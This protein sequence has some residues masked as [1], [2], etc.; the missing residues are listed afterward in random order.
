VRR[1]D[2]RNARLV[3]AF[4]LLNAELDATRA[5]SRRYGWLESSVRSLEELTKGAF[6]GALNATSATPVEDLLRY[7]VV[8]ELHGFGED[9]KRFFCLYFLQAIL[10]LRKNGTT[11]REQLQHVLVFDEAHNV[12]PREKFGEPSV[13]AR[14]ARELREYGEAIISATQQADI[15]ESLIANSGFKFI[16]RCD[17]PRDVQFA[18]AM[19][20]IEPRWL[21]KLPLGHCIARV[22]V[23]FYSP[24]EFLYPDQ[25][26][27]N[28]PTPDEMVHA[29]WSTH[30]LR[31]SAPV[32]P[33][34]VGDHEEELLR[35]VNA[36]PISPITERYVR[37]GW[38]PKTGNTMKDR[39][40]EKRLAVFEPV[41]TPTGVVKI[42]S[43]TDSGR[44]FL[45][46]KQVTVTRSRHGGVEHEY[47]KYRVRQHLER[48]GYTVEEE[49]AIGGGKT[50]DL[51][52]RRHAEKRCGSR[53]KP[54][55]QISQRIFAS[56]RCWKA[57]KCSS[58]PA[59]LFAA[60]TGSQPRSVSRLQNST[61]YRRDEASRFPGPC[62]LRDV[63]LLRDLALEKSLAPQEQ[64][65]NFLF[66]EHDS[67]EGTRR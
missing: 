51:H 50:V 39:V 33:M 4:A 26:L 53:S 20:Q 43:L 58:S 28:A 65:V 19:L 27:K 6:G 49:Y 31:S 17:Y 52:A 10:L 24:F 30:A 56:A 45:V 60:S 2:A 46:G 34:P 22:P 11:V 40:I 41:T 48:R 57:R 5:G 21:P 7:P 29:T 16:L 66:R 42:L 25:P 23:R 9:Q 37:L 35:D 44:A 36:L 54:A 38:N 18:A 13:P 1:G 3:H 12:F 15:S 61:S 14:L 62:R 32:S 47:W 64:H 63:E 59:T 55:A 8:F 67:C